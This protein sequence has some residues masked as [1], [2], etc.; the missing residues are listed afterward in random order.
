MADDIRELNALIADYGR[1]F[2]SPDLRSGPSLASARLYNTGY[3]PATATEQAEMASSFLPGIGEGLDAAH[4]VKDIQDENYGSAGLS[5]LSIMLPF[6]GAGTLKK[7]AG[8]KS[9]DVDEVAEAMVSVMYEDALKKYPDLQITRS[10]FKENLKQTLK[11]ME[12][13]QEP[14]RHS[15]LSPE[16]NRKA[17]EKFKQNKA[18][19]EKLSAKQQARLIVENSKNANLPSVSV[20]K[21]GYVTGP[22]NKPLTLYH[23]THS[24]DP[25]D[26]FDL[27]VEGRLPFLSTST[28][29]KGAEIGSAY[30]IRKELGETGSRTIPMKARATRI[31]DFEK[32]S[33]ILEIRDYMKSNRPANRDVEVD[34]DFIE[35]VIDDMLQGQW[36]TIEKP[37]VREAMAAKGFDAFTTIEGGEKN[38]M[39]MDP[40][41]QVEPLFDPT[42]TGMIGK[43]RRGG[44][45][46]ERSN[47]HEP[48]AI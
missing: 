21:D 46:I 36:E 17:A 5:G 6:V 44:S 42:K 33:D 15:D 47:K 4:F 43:Y 3:Q 23:M 41:R 1:E 9:D 19:M 45:V 24:K 12:A 37:R 38:V 2:Q 34:D 30:N 22:D 29:S 31:L 13:N 35:I 20:S 39:L 28:T 48:K 18:G 11:K 25:F 7:I 16:T 8:K 32:P 26:E 10:Q 27:M 40:V 14:T